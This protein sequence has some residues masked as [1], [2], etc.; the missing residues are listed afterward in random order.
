MYKSRRSPQCTK[1]EVRRLLIQI[2]KDFLAMASYCS[3]AYSALACQHWDVGVGVFRQCEE[4]LI[5][6]FRERVPVRWSGLGQSNA[7][8]FQPDFWGT[9]QRGVNQALMDGLFDTSFVI[10]AELGRNL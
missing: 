3:F 10:L 1:A 4:I 2:A 5:S 9:Q 8:N 6:H 7:L